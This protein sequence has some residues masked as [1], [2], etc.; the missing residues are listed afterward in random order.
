MIL[1]SKGHGWT[2]ARLRAIISAPTLRHDGTVLSAPGYDK[3]T[4]LLLVGDRIW[5]Q[6]PENPSKRDAIKALDV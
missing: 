4:G 1:A 2:V 3:A 5:R 6:V